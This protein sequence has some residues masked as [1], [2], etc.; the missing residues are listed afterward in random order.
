MMYEG[1]DFWDDMND[2][3]P[4]D[5]E[6]TVKARKLEMDFFKKMG[7]YRKV[8]RGEAKRLGCK[9]ITTKWLDTNK[10]DEHTPNYRSRLVGREVKHDK[11]LDLFSATPP[12]E[13]LKLLCSVCARGQGGA[14]PL[15]LAAV[16]IKRAYFYAPTRRP[17]FVEIPAEDR[18]SG[19]ET[20]VGQLQLSLYDTRDAAQNWA[21]EYTTFL[22]GLGFLPGRHGIAMQLRPQVQELSLI[23]I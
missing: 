9:V 11:R 21:H 20:R 1:M 8:P 10:G 22:K 6:M 19:D 23:H 3:K 13:T 18:E 15:R 5:W 4:L 17:I 16:D 7:V 12:L 2:M 14:R